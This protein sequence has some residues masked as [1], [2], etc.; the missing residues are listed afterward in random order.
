MGN[1]SSPLLQGTTSTGFKTEGAIW[2]SGARRIK[3]YEVEL[4]QTGGLSSTDCQVQYDLSRF[5]QTAIL[6]AP[7]VVPSPLDAADGTCLAIFANNATTELTYTTA[8][9]GLGLK[10]WAINQR[11][12]M[13]WRALD[14]GDNI[15][16]AATSL[17]GVGIRGLSSNFTGT[18]VGNINFVE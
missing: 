12:F 6:T 9:V 10:Q 17:V 4:G 1:Y 18:L 13:R 16:V 14:D 15:I 5:S 8:G 3:L 7:L 11:G 2:S